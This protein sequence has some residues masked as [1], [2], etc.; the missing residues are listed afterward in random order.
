MNARTPTWLILL[1]LT[2][3]V[4]LGCGTQSGSASSAIRPRGV[5]RTFRGLRM[6]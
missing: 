3:I 5:S 6:R 2:S 1:A 4:A